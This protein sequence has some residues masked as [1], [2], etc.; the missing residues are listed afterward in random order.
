MARKIRIAEIIPDLHPVTNGMCDA[1]ATGMGG[2]HFVPTDTKEVHILWR[3]F[4][5]SHPNNRVCIGDDET[6]LEQ[7]AWRLQK[8]WKVQLGRR[9]VG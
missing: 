8:G 7:T 3:W 2:V 9:L 1:A 4:G 6:V 5:S